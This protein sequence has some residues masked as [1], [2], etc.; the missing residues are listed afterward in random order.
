M[1]APAEWTPEAVYDVADSIIHEHRHQKLYLV[2]RRADLL[3]QDLPL[4][5]SPWREEPRP[6]SGVLHAVFVFVELRAFW[7]WTTQH[8]PATLRGRAASDVQRIERQLTEGVRVLQTCS[9]T[10]A[11]E[12]L[13]RHLK[14]RLIE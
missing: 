4:V 12:A 9:L 13:V 5:P 3:M 1:G 14:A 2:G 8:G 10:P 6:P 11:G 7:Q